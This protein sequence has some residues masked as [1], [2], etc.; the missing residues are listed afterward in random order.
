MRYAQVVELQA[1]I[2]SYMQNHFVDEQFGRFAKRIGIE[3]AIDSLPAKDRKVLI[4]RWG[5]V[6][7]GA[8]TLKET[9]THFGVSRERI[10]QIEERSIKSIRKYLAELKK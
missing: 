1:L 5:L 4:T 6:E 7:G 10:R 3:D 2:H 9:G 8:R